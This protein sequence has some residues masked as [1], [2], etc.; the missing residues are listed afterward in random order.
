MLLS[1][2]QVRMAP[3]LVAEW[4]EVDRRGGQIK[5]QDGNE[6]ILFCK[7]KVVTDECGACDNAAHSFCLV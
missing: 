6:A 2:S 5:I 4:N 1:Y 3:I 7:K